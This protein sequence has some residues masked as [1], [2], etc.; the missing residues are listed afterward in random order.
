[1]IMA[2][3]P[4]IVAFHQTSDRFYPG[5]NNVPPRMFFTILDLLTAWGFELRAD[6]SF[7]TGRT[8][9]AMITFDDG[10]EDNLPV[11]EALCQRGIRPSLFIPTGT[12]GKTNRW[13]YS[14]RLFPARHLTAEQIN[15]VSAMGVIV[16]SHGVSHRSLT[17]MN[18]ERRMAELADSK[19]TLE[20]LTGKPVDSISF[21]FGRFNDAVIADARACGYARGFGVNRISRLS[22]HN[23][24]FIASRHAVYGNDDYYSLRRRFLK[25]SRWESL[26]DGINWRL[27]GGTTAVSSILK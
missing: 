21:P 27:A 7:D 5:I 8:R 16:G 17:A 11:L 1:M 13:E 19:K 26:Q 14:S 6:S 18:P 10:Y 4:T 25:E 22:I 23:L 12:I 3:E 15:R 2:V 24:S 9:A 20:D